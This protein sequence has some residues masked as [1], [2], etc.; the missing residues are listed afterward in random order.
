MVVKINLRGNEK[1][2]H[3]RPYQHHAIENLR[4]AISSGYKRVLLQAATGAGKT[5]VTR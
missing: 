4:R 1:M 5:D 3:L 2:I